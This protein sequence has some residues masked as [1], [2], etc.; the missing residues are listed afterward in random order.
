MIFGVPREIKTQ[1]F[2][3]GAMPF[4]VKELSRKGHQILVETGAGEH[5]EATDS[6]YE[7]SG[8]TIVPSAEKLYSGAE[9]ILKVREPQPVEIDLIRPDQAIFTF[10][11]FI[12]H[13]DLIKT[14]AAR[15]CTCLSYEF[16]ED[17]DGNHAIMAPISRI[18][19]QM[20][21]TNGA[22]YLQK[23]Y[24]GRGII[25]GH[26]TGSPP[27]SV[28]ILG[29]GH[30]GQ[31][32]AITAANLGASVSVLDVDYRQL[33]TLNALGHQNIT[34]LINSEESLRELLPQTDL[35]ISALRVPGECTPKLI[36][37]EMIRTMKQGS[38][39]MDVDADLGGSL[40]NVKITHHDNPIY[41]V[42]GVIHFSVSNI[43]S[44]APQ[45]ASR[46]LSAALMPFLI[47]VSEHGF[48][49]TL[50]LHPNLAKGITIY[51]GHVVKKFLAKAAGL[52]YT[53]LKQK[54]Q[55]LNPPD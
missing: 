29:A 33:Q 6:Q 43:T 48:E 3:V 17:E 9:V 7:R 36:T 54:I 27:A 19:G 39:I 12:N 14:L 32:A 11:H 28:T 51:K 41:E 5:C 40:E 52:T 15:G 35:L 47:P 2:R 30:V 25:M 20:A 46:A 1:E 18:A 24:G 34:T 45:I 44:A 37:A 50:L 21:V 22:Y 8:A 53:D 4:L 10:F 26:V 49:E 31:Q 42:D 55:E 23:H 13:A 38:V 16:V